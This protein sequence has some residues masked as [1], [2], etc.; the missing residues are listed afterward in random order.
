M[1]ITSYCNNLSNHKRKLLM[2]VSDANL[3]KKPTQ[4]MAVDTYE[5]LLA[6][7]RIVLS[8]KTQQA[9]LLCYINT[10]LIRMFVDVCI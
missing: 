4:N 7:I 8:V 2:A 9:P 3:H 6:D 10:I 1:L 5:W